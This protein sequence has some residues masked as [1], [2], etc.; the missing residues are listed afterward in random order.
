MATERVLAAA[1]LLASLP[2]LA[3][4]RITEALQFPGL[5]A[6]LRECINVVDGAIRPESPALTRAL[7]LAEDH[8]SNQHRGIDPIGIA[9][10]ALAWVLSRQL[11]GASTI[12]Q[13]FVRT[14]TGQYQRSIRRKFRE[15]LLAVLLSR[16][17]SKD[18]ICSAY[19]SVAFF[20]H[21]HVGVSSV[22]RLVGVDVNA[23]D[24]MTAL[25]LMAYLKYPRPENPTIAWKSKIDRRSM[26]LA[27]RH[28]RLVNK[29]AQQAMRFTR[30]N[31]SVSK[32]GLSQ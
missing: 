1:V 28:H 2:Y 9:R 15:Q 13:Q 6:D 19:L 8:R 21:G 5:L 12:E 3:L 14:V 4:A 32:A 23:V 11:Q 29:A 26:Y 7:V 30:A 20:G 17:R 10:A 22:L 27:M 18:A 16:H 31:I 25:R 24:D